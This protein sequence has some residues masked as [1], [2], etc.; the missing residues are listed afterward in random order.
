M[1]KE[2]RSRK[3]KHRVDRGHQD[4]ILHIAKRLVKLEN[5]F[6]QEVDALLDEIGLDK[7]ELM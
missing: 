6:N 5:I 7:A 4:R 2:N 3:G 1:K